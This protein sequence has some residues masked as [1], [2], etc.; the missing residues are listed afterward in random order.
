MIKISNPRTN[1]NTHTPG[2]MEFM[3]GRCDGVAGLQELIK[4]SQIYRG[5]LA[6]D[7]DGESSM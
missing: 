5:K 7:H 3:T 6:I 1:G 4:K 2:I